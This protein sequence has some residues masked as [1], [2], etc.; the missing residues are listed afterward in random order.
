MNE[1]LNEMEKSMND[2]FGTCDKMFKD[3]HKKKVNK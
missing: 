2:F 1:I 3:Y